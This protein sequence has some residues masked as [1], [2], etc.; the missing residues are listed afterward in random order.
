MEVCG[1]RRGGAVGGGKKT[2]LQARQE[3]N[4]QSEEKH[5][6]SLCLPRGHCV[7]ASGEKKCRSK[8]EAFSVF[9]TEWIC[10][11][12]FPPSASFCAKQDEPLQNT[13]TV[14]A[15][16]CFACVR[17]CVFVRSLRA[18]AC[19]RSAVLQKACLSS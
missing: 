15:V 14:V 18:A 5:Q 8:S 1:L 2:V 16:T 19:V 6:Q 4:R 7:R 10:S 12:Y 3:E 11:G 13:A 17:V 9:L